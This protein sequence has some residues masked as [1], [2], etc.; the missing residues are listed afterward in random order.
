VS[1]EPIASPELLDELDRAITEHLAWLKAWHRALLCEGGGDVDAVLATAGALS[2]FGTWFLRNQNEGLVDQP[3]VRALAG[4]ERRIRGRGRALAARAAA[5]QPLAAPDYEAWMD[6]VARFVA[7][8]RRLERAFVAAFSDLDPLTGIPNRQAME[9][10]LRRE[11][12]R[13]LRTARPCAIGLADIDHFKAINDNHGHAAG[14]R[15]LAAVADRFAAALRPYDAVYRFGGEEFLFC[16]PEAGVDDALHVMQRILDALRGRDVP[17]P[18]SGA[19]A[20]TCSFGVAAIGAAES[21]EE[22]IARA[23]RALYMAKAAGRAR[24]CAAPPAPP[25]APPLLSP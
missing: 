14:D 10:D 19:I 3:A 21:L 22:T 23:D 8:A 11:R 24:V 4:L 20:V 2:R 15:V 17:L 13:A 6:D 12:A 16:L 18:G 7:E 9:R 1:G 25:A 5:G